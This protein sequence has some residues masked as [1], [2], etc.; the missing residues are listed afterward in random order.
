M[1]CSGIIIGEYSVTEKGG[2]PVYSTHEGTFMVI[3]GYT[4][5]LR[6]LPEPTSEVC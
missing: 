5:P 4:F 2:I 6:P 3:K 1:T